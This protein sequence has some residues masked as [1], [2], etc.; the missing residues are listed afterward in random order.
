MLNSGLPFKNTC[1]PHVLEAP[2][3]QGDSSTPRSDP[4]LM[5]REAVHA[6][7][8]KGTSFV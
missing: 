8:P 4:R 1:S 2:L 5:P 6:Q 3:D 7:S